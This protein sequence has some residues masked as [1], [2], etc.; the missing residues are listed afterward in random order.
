MKEA[1]L[2]K[3]IADLIGTL[4]LMD[5]LGD[6]EQFKRYEAAIKQR[7]EARRARHEAK[8]AVLFSR[9]TD[10]A[11]ALIAAYEREGAKVN[12]F[13]TDR[14]SGNVAVMM[15]G[16]QVWDQRKQRTVKPLIM[17]YPDGTR[18]TT[19]ERSVTLKRHF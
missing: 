10:K 16:R 19:N 11:E 5:I 7:R 2:D 6:P 15:V 14:S 17:V 13:F 9:L 18:T 4:E 1:N 8:V 3:L 12:K